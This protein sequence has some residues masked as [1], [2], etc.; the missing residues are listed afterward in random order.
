MFK[1]LKTQILVVMGAMV[2]ILII[3]TSL[4]RSSQ[5]TI[6]ASYQK[7]SSAL[8]EVRLVHELERDVLDL[9]R[10]VLIYKDTA[11]ESARLKF[12]ELM[13]GVEEKISLF[14]LSL[15]ENNSS[16]FQTIIKSMRGHLK[17]YKSNFESVVAGR[18][19]TRQLTEHLIADNFTTIQ[20]ILENA[21]RDWL[22]A[23]YYLSEAK[24]SYQ[25]YLIQPDHFNINEFNQ[26]HSKFAE[27]ISFDEGLN[28]ELLPMA[29]DLQSQVIKLSQITRGYIFLVNV[30]MAGSANEFFYLTQELSQRVSKIQNDQILDSLS[31]A[32]TSQKLTDIVA[33]VCMLIAIFIAIVVI[34]RVIL[35]IRKITDVFNRLSNE[36]EIDKIPERNRNDEIGEL[37][38]AASIFHAKNQQTTRLLEESTAMF[39]QQELLNKELAK[40]KDRA[41]LAAESKS[42]FLAN[43]SHEIR[44]PMNGIVGLINLALKTNLD[45]LQRGY[46]E[47]V[48]YS[49]QILMGVINDILD[50]SKIEAGKLDIESIEFEI[51]ELVG[52][53]IA[54]MHTHIEDKKLDFRVDVMD[55]VPARIISDPLRINQV[56]LNLCSNAIKFTELGSVKVV[57]DYS[58]STED[59][60]QYLTIVVSDTGIGM[61]KTK[62]NTI[63]D[64]FAQAD[65]STSRKYGGTGLGL[66]IVK[67]LTELMGGSIT[68]DSEPDVGSR[69]EVRFRIENTEK[70]K[71]HKPISPQ[72]VAIKYLS[73][74]DSSLINNNVLR[75]K[76][77]IADIIEPEIYINSNILNNRETIL[78]DTP[79]QKPKEI[80]LSIIEKLNKFEKNIGVILPRS[81]K[82]SIDENKLLGDEKT[83]YYPYTPQELD[84]FLKNIIDI[85]YTDENTNT[86]LDIGACNN[87]QN[88]FSGRVLLVEDNEINQLVASTML[89]DFGIEVHLAEDGKQ[90]V[91]K[92]IE[93]Q[94]YDLILM[95]IQMPVMDGY[96]AT[97]KLRS[98]GYTDIAICGLSA[99]AMKEDY[100]KAGQAGMNDYLTKPIDEGELINRLDKYLP[101]TENVN[102]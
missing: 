39:K 64:A 1:S 30:V 54:L 75:E 38:K 78:I 91:D 58:N 24:N 44:T 2:I 19:Q 102:S 42:M 25:N 85:P 10:N 29:N 17:D 83:L 89:E 50:F 55:Q 47:K 8:I 36:E 96:E 43:M 92:F 93:F 66:A 57:I 6:V 40:E 3:Q 7:S 11:S 82:N 18:S 79:H 48:S 22:E 53:F 33:M 63:F 86:K 16:D 69:F 94:D 97:I 46:L 71:L 35:P 12:Q 5:Q 45:T 41:E 34:R 95:D 90:A 4:T 73:K 23:K 80:Y 31:A 62:L 14:D 56:M 98:A 15:L 68:V 9:Q 70:E 37:S 59:K 87:N 100:E 65:G 81:E 72:P 26:W 27:V 76:A 101:K 99:N 74:V 77:I 88:R 67:Q 60:N 13:R 20:N 21:S 51:D 61:S 49:S 32:K 28:T 84:N 52:S